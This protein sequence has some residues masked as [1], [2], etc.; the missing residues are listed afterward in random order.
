MIVTDD[1]ELVRHEEHLHLSTETV[2][3]ETVRIEKVI[4]TET[5]TF[6]KDV[7]REE[8]RITRT[9]AT[10]QNSLPPASSNNRALPIVIVLREEQLTVTTT[11]VPVERITVNVANV[12][13]E[14]HVSEP[15]R[16][17]HIDVVEHRLS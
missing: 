1:P 12:I 8:L 13:S 5:R 14:Q 17:E 6:T 10:G 7:R 2:P 4:V 3:V 11:I 15:I 9:P 16:H